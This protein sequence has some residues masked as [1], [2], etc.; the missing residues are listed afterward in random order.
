MNKHI[1]STFDSFLIEEDIFTETSAEAI[2]RVIAWQIKNFLAMKHMTKSTF[3]KQLKTS[4]SQLDRLL[5]PDNT[6]ISLKTLV[7]V[8]NAMNK[9]VEIAIS[10]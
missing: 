10:D 6:T 4:R 1:G 9:H 5:D 3:A 2:K 8:A 7:S